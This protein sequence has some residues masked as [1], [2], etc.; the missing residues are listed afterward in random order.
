VLRSPVVSNGAP[1]KVFKMASTD[2]FSMPSSPFKESKAHPFTMSSSPLPSPSDLHKRHV[3]FAK[4][5]NSSTDILGSGLLATGSISFVKASQ[6][7]LPTLNSIQLQKTP[8]ESIE[9]VNKRPVKATSNSREKKAP[10]KKTNTREVKEQKA[11]TGVATKKSTDP[12]DTPK[13][14]QPRKSRAKKA[15]AETLQDGEGVKDATRY[16]ETKYSTAVKA[17]TARKSRAK[18][19]TEEAQ[20]KLLCPVTKPSTKPKATRTKA[21]A[22]EKNT[23]IGTDTVD[24]GLVKAIKRRTN[25]SPPSKP[26]MADLRAV[27][28]GLSEPL[29]AVANGFNGM[30]GSFAFTNVAPQGTLTTKHSGAG[31][32]KKRKL[33]ELVNTSIT[34]ETASPKAKAPK[35][36]ATTITG[37]AISAFAEE[38]ADELEPAPLLQYLSY[39]TTD[40]S[41]KTVTK[42]A[43]KSR[44]RSPVKKPKKGSNAQLPILLSPESAL[45]QARQQDFVFGTSSQL[46]REESPAYLRDLHQAMQ[47]S[48]VE[49]DTFE[50]PFKDVVDEPSAVAP[51]GRSRMFPKKGGL[52]SAGARDAAGSLLDVKMVDI[53]DTPVASRQKSPH[54]TTAAAPATDDEWHDIEE[55]I[56]V[57]SKP[58]APTLGTPSKLGPV[59]AAI[60]L[61]L[62]NSPVVTSPVKAKSPKR[63]RANSK[64]IV[65]AAGKARKSTKPTDE[66]I[67]DFRAYTMVQLQKQIARYHFKPIKSRDVMI[68]VLEKCWEGQHKRSALASLTTNTKSPAKAQKARVAGQQ[69]TGAL[70]TQGQLMTASTA[71]APDS[72]TKTKKKLGRSKKADVTESE[73]SDIPLSQARKS[74]RSSKKSPKKTAGK[75]STDPVEDVFDSEPHLMPSPSCR[76][77]RPSQIGALPPPL[78]LLTSSSSVDALPALSQESL[79]DHITIAIKSLSP[80]KDPTKPTW[81]EKILLYDPIVLEDL[82][83]WLNTGALE[84]IGWDGEVEPKIVKKWCESKGICCLWKENLRGGSRSRY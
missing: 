46:A 74:K 32:I 56:G 63:S 81:H 25:W 31:V 36:K 26:S 6:L 47:A 8:E 29:D 30:L 42:L 52:W 5:R 65:P 16:C 12:K 80:T 60:R 50:D 23:D 44:S 4:D 72:P 7:D 40:R 69:E 24:H 37:L 21:S 77:R 41:T 17:K 33:I 62:L 57:M 67:P 58:T 20:T 15:K 11:S 70:E 2:I 53:T 61:Q 48:N 45:K 73:D 49:V 78:K 28:D 59:E 39:K 51:R 27:A 54:I 66:Q 64:E 82:T 18:R 10:T 9:L 14:K 79:F 76:R 68:A 84:N 43:A 22:S 35:K 75:S 38:K 71:D 1:R 34:T 3:P 19:T 55:D 13:E 83:V